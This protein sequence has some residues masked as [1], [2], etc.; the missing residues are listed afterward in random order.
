MAGGG[1][2]SHDGPLLWYYVTAKK[3]QEILAEGELRPAAIGAPAKEK[4]AVWFSANQE[5]EPAA[6][7]LW[8][9]PR[10]AM[11]RLGRDQ[12]FVLGGGLARTGVA[13]EVAPHDWKTFKRL[14]GISPKAAREL[15]QT[16]IAAGSR[17]ADWH[18]S[19]EAVPR[20]RWATIEVL[21]DEIWVT[22]REPADR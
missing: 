12:T 8:E 2:E 7:E 15:Y 9:D 22:M 21:E 20:S 16:A 5:W 14:S 11:V 4:P 19:F 17:P 3:L 6:N 13:A 1:E 18:A 10:G